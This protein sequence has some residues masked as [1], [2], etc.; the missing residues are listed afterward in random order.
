[1]AV[2]KS[3]LKTEEEK[4]ERKSVAFSKSRAGT[5]SPASIPSASS[6]QRSPS[7]RLK[8]AGGTVHSL[9]E[10]EKPGFML[11]T[12][13]EITVP[14]SAEDA[15]REFNS[16]TNAQRYADPDTIYSHNVYR[17]DGYRKTVENEPR[18]TAQ[19]YYSDAMAAKRTLEADGL[20]GLGIDRVANRAAQAAVNAIGSGIRNV[21]NVFGADTSGIA[22]WQNSAVRG[23]QSTDAGRQNAAMAQARRDYTASAEA[24]NRASSDRLAISASHQ[25]DFTTYSKYDPNKGNDKDFDLVYEQVNGTRRY[26]NAALEDAASG[27]PFRPRIDHNYSQLTNDERAVYNYYYNTGDKERAQAYLDSIYPELEKRRYEADTEFNRQYATEHPVAASVVSPALGAVS[28]IAAIP[29]IAEQIS[30]GRVNPY[31][32]ANSV[33]NTSQQYRNTVAENIAKSGTFGA[34]A[35]SFLYQTGMDFLESTIRAS[36]LGGI[37]G[38]VAQGLGATAEGVKAAATTASL[39]PMALG[40]YQSTS[41]DMKLKGYS[42]SEAQTIGAIAAGAEYLTEK[43]PLEKLYDTFMASSAGTK[44]GFL[45]GLVKQFVTEGG[46]E[47]ISDLI[48][49][50]ADILLLGDRSEWSN[51]VKEYQA[52][53]ATRGEAIKSAFID[54][55]KEIGLDILGGGLSGAASHAIAYGG[56]A[57]IGKSVNAAA[58]SQTAKAAEEVKAKAEQIK[59]EVK[60]ASAMTAEEWEAS[61]K[62]QSE[63]AKKRRAAVRES[64]A[65]LGVSEDMIRS[66]EA[67]SDVTGQSVTF[68]SLDYD[69]LSDEQ[70][71]NI[72]REDFGRISLNGYRNDTTGEIV[73]NSNAKTEEGIKF[74]LGHELG[75]SIEGGKL[76]TQLRDLAYEY[77]ARNGKDWNKE[78]RDLLAE[79]EFVGAENFDQDSEMTANFAGKFLL[80]NVESIEWLVNSNHSVATRVWNWINEKLATRFADDETAT[81]AVLTRAREL[82]GRA[83]AANAAAANAGE[84]SART[85]PT[86]NAQAQQTQTQ[87]AP[88]AVQQTQTQTTQTAEPAEPTGEGA[89]SAMPAPGMMPT[90]AQADASGEMSEYQQ[91]AAELARERDSGEISQEGYEEELE[92]LDNEYQR[93]PLAAY[94]E[95]MREAGLENE[96]GERTYSVT[97]EDEKKVRDYVDSLPSNTRFSVSAPVEKVETEDGRHLLALHNVNTENL[98]KMLSNWGK[99][100]APSIA[101]IRDSMT[102]DEFGDNTVVFKS[103]AVD[104]QAHEGN[105]IYAGD[106]YTGVM[107]N[108]ADQSGWS[109]ETIAEI[110]GNDS[111][112]PTVDELHSLDEVRNA[113]DRLSDRYYE[114]QEEIQNKNQEIKRYISR[115]SRDIVDGIIDDVLYKSGYGHINAYD[116]ANMVDRVS[117]D[118]ADFVTSALGKLYAEKRSD[119]AIKEL[120]AKRRDEYAG[121]YGYKGVASEIYSIGTNEILNLVNDSRKAAD[122]FADLATTDPGEPYF[123]AKSNRAIG[124]D[125]IAGIVLSEDVEPELVDLLDS[126]GI[127]YEMYDGY[128][129]DA[130]MNAVNRIADSVEGAKFSVTAE[131]DKA[132]LSAARSGDTRTAQRMVDEAAR[133]AGY[134]KYKYNNTENINPN[135]IA[136]RNGIYRGREAEVNDRAAK[137]VEWVGRPILAYIYGDGYQAITGSHRIYIARKADIDVKAVVMSEEDISDL[138]EYLENSD[139]GYDI[140]DFLDYLDEDQQA[141]ILKGAVDDGYDNLKDAYTILAVESESNNSEH[142]DQLVN[143]PYIRETSKGL[144]VKSADPI[145]Y[146]DNGAIIPLSERFDPEKDDIRWS[147]TSSLEPL[148]LTFKKGEN[149]ET[150]LTDANGNQINHVTEEMIWNSDY[151]ALLRETMRNED[152][153]EGIIT[154]EDAKAEVKFFS[155]MFNMMLET[156]DIDLIW[157][158]NSSIG[159]Q[160]VTPGEEF[161]GSNNRTNSKFAALTSNSDPQYGTTVDFTTICKKTQAVI[162]VMS[163][164]MKRKGK[165]LTA[166]EIINI[167]YDEVA[168]AGEPVPCPV[169]YVFSRWVGLGGLFDSIKNMQDQY[170]EG[171][172]VSQIRSDIES[173][174]KTIEGFSGGKFGDKKENYYKSIVKE[175]S[176]L[177]KKQFDAENMGGE[178][179]TAAEKERLETVTKQIRYIDQWTWLKDVRLRND[180]KPVPTEIL[181]DINAGKRFA[182]EYPTTWAYRTSRGPAMGKAATPY[183]EE[184]LGQVIRGLASPSAV[185]KHQLGDLSKDPYLGTGGSLGKISKAMLKKAQKNARK[186]NLLNGQRLQSTSDF[187][188]EYS[189]DYL[190]VFFELQSVGAKAQMYTKVPEMVSMV[191]SCNIEGNLSLMP[192]GDGYDENGNLIFSDVTGMN[193][194]D[195]FRYSAMHDCIQPI[196]VGINNRHVRLCLRDPRITFCIPFHASGGTED[197]YTSMMRSI[198]E[199]VTNRTDYSHYQN[200]TQK[201]DATPE[202]KNAYSARIKILTGKAS[203]MS[204]A[205]KSAVRNNEILSQLHIR[206]YGKDVDGNQARADEMY[207]NPDDRTGGRDSETY[208]NF[209]STAQAHKIMPYEFWDKTA[210]IA[211]EKVNGDRF[212]DYCESLG[213][214]ARFSGWSDTGT[215]DPEMDFTDESGYWKVIPDRKMY[216]N[217][218]TYHVQKAVNIANF[219]TEYLLPDKADSEIVKPSRSNDPTKV[220]SIADRAIERISAERAAEGMQFSVT[221]NSEES[222]GETE[223]VVRKPLMTASEME[224]ADRILRNAEFNSKVSQ[225]KADA[226]ARK[227]KAEANAEGKEIIANSREVG[228]AYEAVGKEKGDRLVRNAQF[229]SAVMQRQAKAESKEIKAGA[230]AES[231]EILAN[232]R[233]AGKAYEALGKEKGERKGLHAQIVGEMRGRE[234]IRKGEEKGAAK[235]EN[236]TEKANAII[237]NAQEVDQAYK[238]IEK[239]KEQARRDARKA[240]ADRK[241]NRDITVPASNDVNGQREM[242]QNLYQSQKKYKSATASKWMTASDMA[243]LRDLMAGTISAEYDLVGSDHPKMIREAFEALLEYDKAGRTVDAYGEQVRRELRETAAEKLKNS[244]SF[245]DKNYG[246]KYSRETERRNI[247][248]IA[249]AEDAEAINQEYFYPVMKAAR[250]K[251]SLLRKYNGR[252]KALGIS[253]KVLK[254]NKVSEAYAVQLLG[255]I[256][257]IKRELERATDTFMNKTAP[258]KIAKYGQT[259]TELDTSGSDLDAVLDEMGVPDPRKEKGQKGA[260]KGRIAGLTADEQ[261]AME[262]MSQGE[263]SDYIMSKAPTKYGMTLA[264]YEAL[265]QKFIKE[266]PNLDYA[267]VDRKIDGMRGIYDELENQLNETYMR[268]G[269]PPLGHI[270]GYFPH[271]INDSGNVLQKMGKRLGLSSASLQ[272]PT[273]IVGQTAERKPGVK[274]FANKLTRNT[275]VTDYDAIEGYARYIEGATD[276]IAFTESIQKLRAY[277]NE[278][279]Y[280]NSDK[281]VQEEV[282]AI[283]RDKTKSLSEKY[284]DIEQRFADLGTDKYALNN[285]VQNV[286]EYTN[287]LAGKKSLLDRGMEG[288]LGRNAL[289]RGLNAYNRLRAM[290]AVSMN[291]TSALTNIIP[292]AQVTGVAGIGNTAKAFGDTIVN[293]FSKGDGLRE[294]SDFLMTREG[295]TPVN[296]TG[297]EKAIDA[298]GI[299]FNLLDRLGAETV[300]RANYYYNKKAGL[301]TEAA[302]AKADIEAD[303]TI[304]GRY[305]GA[306][307]TLFNSQNPIVQMGTRF[308]QETNNFISYALKD[309]PRERRDRKKN[310]L[311]GEAIMFFCLWLYNEGFQALFGRRPAQE[312]S[313]LVNDIAGDI[314][315]YRMPNVFRLGETLI[316]EKRLP[317]AEDFKT[318][319]G[320][321]VKDVTSDVVDILPFSGWAKL[322]SDVFGFDLDIQGGRFDIGDSVPDFGRLK[323]AGDQWQVWAEELSKPVTSLIPGGNQLQKTVKGAATMI[324]GGSYKINNKGER[325]LQYPA[326]QSAGNWA[327]AII[328][329]KSSLPTAQEW[330]EK[331]FDTLS[332]KDTEI[333]DMLTGYDVKPDDAL[334]LIKS[335]NAIQKTDEESRSTLQ[336]KALID[337]GI[338]QT[339]KLMLYYGKFA[340]D[341]EKALIDE[342]GGSNGDALLKAIDG[343][344]NSSTQGGDIKAIIGSSLSGNDK[345][346]MYDDYVLGKDSRERAA[347]EAVRNGEDGN[348]LMNLIDGVKS[349]VKTDEESAAKQKRDLLV[350]SSLSGES[351]LTLYT[352]SGLFGASEKEIEI[353]KS[354]SG[355]ADNDELTKAAARLKLSAKG[356][357]DTLALMEASLPRDAKKELY[358]GLCVDADGREK[359]ASQISDITGAGLNFD[360][361]L[362]IANKY[363]ELNDNKEIKAGAK[364]TD[365]SYW[366]DGQRYTDRQKAAAQEAFGYYSQV[367]AKPSGYEKMTDTGLSADAAYEINRQISALEPKPGKSQVSDT[368]KAQVIV[369]QQGLTDEEKL[370]ALRGVYSEDS[371]TNYSKAYVA[372]SYGVPLET[373]YK[374]IDRCLEVDDDPQYASY[375]PQE[376]ARA[377]IDSFGEL[378]NRQKAAIWQCY[379]VNWSAKSNPFDQS[380]GAYVHSLYYESDGKTRKDIMPGNLPRQAS[381][382]GEAAAPS[383]SGGSSSRTAAEALT[384]GTMPTA[385]QISGSSGSSGRSAGSALAGALSGRR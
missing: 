111:A 367:R 280:K 301:S 288:Q 53:G 306:R 47:G 8:T 331:G 215:Y 244:N 356:Y 253:Q 196:I 184:H 88:A 319:K 294:M 125:E 225:R 164:I 144:Q 167:V 112:D 27:N 334:G 188:Y 283:M 369:S 346:T 181:F 239:D 159:F 61:R 85:L 265:E 56:G 132:Y 275:N 255:E 98:Y 55:T 91:R 141:E 11:P 19:G 33:L 362:K 193:A 372:V 376:R 129:S 103:E 166:K 292:I 42:D 324:A 100:P 210:T 71:K 168:K 366:L 17:G 45:R 325:Q 134:E 203:S 191:A 153:P 140:N 2:S 163:D 361:Y 311:L 321:L 74:I 355:S 29:G 273:E 248:D 131:E 124:T 352:D 21:G 277:V 120:M 305:K 67:A 276:V 52:Q 165:G 199:N 343:C 122:G 49:W 28:G 357:D 261:N 282:N 227:I 54:K 58:N 232:A 185:S 65:S 247:R 235:I 371:N 271:F 93:D 94:H 135:S 73:L 4:E 146:D 242:F 119:T 39:V 339:A 378:T 377:V 293:M 270:E 92:S 5:V 189:L 219:Q 31:S 333:Y 297:F 176:L 187:R 10:E 383:S 340:G 198:E 50:A 24:F 161:G 246:F 169:C 16:F 233:E 37:G 38:S 262:T 63:T 105:R 327:R 66:V 172:D 136:P 316:S 99:I 204:E 110:I 104:P 157:A 274:W 20:R 286:T 213:V 207:L 109:A 147:V 304:S 289:Y 234:A 149:G 385:S 211:D 41:N 178:P 106:A 296:Q 95:D 186:Q 197:N 86:A 126:M 323:T 170:P 221:D 381:S 349:A 13:R 201:A 150:I 173:L 89:L 12:A 241:A 40:V 76:W 337:S 123:E 18:K 101:I 69:S 212:V 209:L 90:A 279:R 326:E 359:K 179:L 299:L 317:T 230:E 223:E 347:I 338:D 353:L 238:A 224:K 25:G 138:T 205:E 272:L 107:P 310:V 152:N 315:G 96:R 68:K 190:M 15:Q 80:D 151:G 365:F 208:E 250:K 268:W 263:F 1:M 3:R 330:V 267:A 218:G 35:A 44:T 202:Q 228:K 127:R 155:D 174:R 36:L 177:E 154:Y 278:I 237:A 217:D 83:L 139:D 348:A 360:D 287:N 308:V 43:L 70:K 264:E 195:A 84:E 137:M 7:G 60:A 75:H 194:E 200:D 216:N 291:I 284:F 175:Q 148:D 183:A 374:V 258:G 78:A 257:A 206:F 48:N 113:S 380:V 298:A 133:K 285:Y 62:D 64:G 226:E 351:K 6:L 307:P 335:L 97:E 259:S 249:P 158:I 51:S 373:Y 240:A 180:Y 336:R 156:Q 318:E 214:H 328:A 145:T 182:E 266:N 302:A 256:R 329:G 314:T 108:D 222:A 59:G 358:L 130:R 309:V 260:K 142:V 341:R 160:P 192:R 382:S 252:V 364:A 82:Y 312:P 117:E 118:V 30:T 34:N 322:L 354:L 313:E 22:D 384:S 128:D 236:A 245:K 254:G 87:T 72:S 116:Y 281:A 171:M 14:S 143:D 295:V 350:N 26:Q 345:V 269:Y 32:E 9:T 243:K 332:V 342:I 23:L 46:E 115:G 121:K 114:I 77:Y 229:S 162:D 220:S 231:K 102:H 290:S 79:L 379:T 303:E 368:Q 81:K 251:D 57:L 300:W 344:I 363:Y 375:K 370:S 320:D